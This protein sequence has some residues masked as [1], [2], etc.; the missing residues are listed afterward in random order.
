MIDG[1][2]LVPAD[3]AAERAEHV[4]HAALCPVAGS[5]ACAANGA[6]A[7]LTDTGTGLHL[8]D[9]VACASAA[10]VVDGGFGFVL[11]QLLVPG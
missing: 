4:A 5:A 10:D 2:L 11:H 7:A 6:G 8:V 3:G 1:T 9:C